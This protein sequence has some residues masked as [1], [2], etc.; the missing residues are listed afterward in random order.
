MA[1]GR[2][3]SSRKKSW[4]PGSSQPSNFFY[5]AGR[6]VVVVI[7]TLAVEPAVFALE[8]AVETGISGVSGEKIISIGWPA[9]RKLVVKT[10]KTD[11][12]SATVMEAEREALITPVELAAMTATRVWAKVLIARSLAVLAKYLSYII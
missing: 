8:L 1:A 11:A 12:P 7:L 5:F 3:S 6:L 10:D 2:C 4:I 9:W